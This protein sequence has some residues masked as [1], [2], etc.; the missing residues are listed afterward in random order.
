MKKTVAMSCSPLMLGA[1]L[2]PSLRGRPLHR[3]ADLRQQPGRHALFAAEPDHARQCRPS[4]SGSGPST[5]VPP[6]STIPPRP[7]RPPAAAAAAPPPAVAAAPASPAA[8]PGFPDDAAGGEWPDVSGHALSPRHRLDAETG[9]QV[10]AY[11][12]PG[13]TTI[14][15]PV[16][17]NIGRAATVPRA[18][19]IVSTQSGKIIALNAKTGEPVAGFGTDGILDTR[20]PEIL[21]GLPNT[22]FGYSSPPLVVNNV[23]VTGGRVQEAPTLGAA[24]DVR[25]WDIRTGKLLWTFPY[26]SASGREGQRDLGQ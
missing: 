4:W 11:D 26:R 2:V 24:G 21:N 13:T 15:P 14:L 22:A 19:V 8:L 7:R 9:K 1:A 18:R 17:P 6:I 5:C 12:L 10:W 20:T 16:A 25:G 23:L 3:M